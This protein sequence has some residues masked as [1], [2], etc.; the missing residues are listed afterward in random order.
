MLGV[1]MVAT[2][3]AFTAC[4]DDE[5][6]PVSSADKEL[7]EL[8]N[9]LFLDGSTQPAFMPTEDDGFYYTNS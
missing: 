7:V 4:S 9:L 1:L 6:T 2:G 5:G 8:K 3:F